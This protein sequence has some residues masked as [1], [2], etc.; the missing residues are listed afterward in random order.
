MSK[1]VTRFAPSPT[2]NLHIGG[3]RTALFNYLFTRNNDGKYLLRI[4]DTDKAR[5]T[6]AFENNIIDGFKNIGLNWDNNNILRQSE[7]TEIYSKYLKKLIDEGK[8]YVSKEAVVEEGGRAEVIRLKNPNKKISFD[9]L[10]RDHVE[11]DTTDLG[12]FVIAK[13]LSEP[14]YHFASVIDDF[15]MGITHVIRAEEHLSN[16]PRQILIQ[17]AIG[18]NRPIYAHIPM[19]LAPDRS[20]LSKRHGATALTDYLEK[21]YL[22]EAIINYLAFLGWN[23]GGEREIYSLDELIKIF[24][25]SKV[26]KAAAIFNIEKL[27]WYNREYI[28]KLSNEDFINYSKPFIPEWL[29]VEGPQFKRLLP[30]LRE[31]IVV[32]S[33]IEKM[34]APNSEFGFIRSLNDYTCNELLWKKNPDREVARKHLSYAKEII[35]KIDTE[36]NLNL[37]NVANGTD[38]FT[39]DSIKNSLWKY[40]EENGKGDVL[41]P[42][43]MALTGQEKSPDPFVSAA[44]LGKEES[45]RRI[46]LAL[47]K[48]A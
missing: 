26:Q 24:D 36:L 20:K 18:A 14:I 39:S 25:I 33:D 37:S 6:K 10:I 40:A 15:E 23:P 16:T 4:D 7:R 48:L 31:K 46:D 41:W 42:L 44:I 17:E 35:Q 1:I 30:L 21:G 34:F 32:F 5:S 13:S 28:G 47:V 9:D 3:V 11:F 2:G 22:K 43:R 38:S 12:D 29:S 8:A 45:L 27:D 19:I